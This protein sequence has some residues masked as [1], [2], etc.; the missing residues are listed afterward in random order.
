[1][2]KEKE[3]KKKTKEINRQRWWTNSEKLERE[4]ERNKIPGSGT[5]EFQS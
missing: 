3:K 2:K 4:N 1:V 5:V